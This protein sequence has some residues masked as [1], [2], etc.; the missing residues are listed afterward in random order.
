MSSDPYISFVVAAR[1]DNHGGDFLVRFGFFLKVLHKFSYDYQLPIE[2]VVVEWNPPQDRPRLI[3]DVDWSKRHNYCSV[4]FIEVPSEIHHRYKYSHELGLY[5]MIAKNVGIRRSQGEFIVATNADIIFSAELFE[6][7]SKKELCS[8]KMYR[9]DRMDV[10]NNIDKDWSVQS[11]LDYCRNNISRVNT[12]YDIYDLAND[13]QVE[14]YPGEWAS[15]SPYY[16]NK[17][18]AILHNNACGDFQLMRKD[19]WFKV[20]GYPESDM[21]SFH[22]DSLLAHIVY[23]HGIQEEILNNK[24][25]YHIEHGAGWTNKDSE[26]LRFKMNLKKVPM[27]S[28]PQ[29]FAMGAKMYKEQ[30]PMIFNDG[31][32]GLVNEKLREN[33]I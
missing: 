29:I 22:L 12:K 27:L 26:S 25:I 13:V 33:C 11:L 17:Q 1:N 20:L 23:H 6:F 4:R 9:I 16:L 2:I 5:Q 8:G 18:G 21:F 30:K 32:W 24:V 28:D 15:D 3:E 7:F 19:D 14:I 10:N 31:S